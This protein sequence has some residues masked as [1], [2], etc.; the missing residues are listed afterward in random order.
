[1]FRLQFARA[2]FLFGLLPVMCCL[3]I[4]CGGEK[5]YRISGKVTFKGQPIAE[6][7]I[8]FNPDVTKGN[9]GPGGFAVI[10][11]GSY[12]TA[13]TGGQGIVGGPMIV[14]IEGFDP[15]AKSDKPDSAGE[16]TTKALFPAYQTPADLPKSDSTK[17]FD[18]PAD[19]GKGKQGGTGGAI[20]P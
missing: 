20:I 14:K 3:A 12:D 5:T 2:A 13:A 4:G 16:I 7:M 8:Y 15:A 6:G 1:M 10:K 9:K 17:D 11:E 18:V 19:A